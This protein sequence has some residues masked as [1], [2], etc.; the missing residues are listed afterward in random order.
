MSNKYAGALT[1]YR[2]LRG[3]L[4]S[5]S[6]EEKILFFQSSDETWYF[7]N[8]DGTKEKMPDRN[9]S[10]SFVKHTGRGENETSD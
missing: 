9:I 1:A 4:P 6:G 5:H 8:D 2:L 10:F 3:L 7:I